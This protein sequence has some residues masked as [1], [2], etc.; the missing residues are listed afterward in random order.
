MK[1]FKYTR[2]KRLNLFLLVYLFVIY[3]FLFNDF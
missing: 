3:F 1:L 2:R